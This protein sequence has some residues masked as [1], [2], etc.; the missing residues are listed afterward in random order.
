MKL[1]IALCLA[2]GCLIVGR[3]EARAATLPVAHDAT[4]REALRQSSGF[5]KSQ[6]FEKAIAAVLPLA[7]AHADDYTLNVRLGWLNYLD[8]KYDASE[9]SYRAAIEAAPQ[10]IE[11][12]LG[13]LLPLLA[14]AKYQTAESV[15][16]QILETDPA[17][18]L[19]NLRLAVALRLQLKLDEAQEIVESNLAKYPADVYFQAE[20]AS[21]SIAGKP[22][23]PVDVALAKAIA[24]SA[25]FE[26]ALDFDKA[27]DA[28]GAQIKSH[29]RNYTLA[30]R[31]AWLHYLK[32]EYGIAER[33]YQ[34]AARLAPKS[35]EA[36]LGGLLAL[37]AELKYRNAEP[38]AQQVIRSDPSNYYA[39][40]RLAVAMRNL[41]KLPE[42][43]KVVH[44][45]LALYPA[46]TALMTELGLIAQA[47]NKPDRAKQLFLEVVALDSTNATALQQLDGLQSVGGSK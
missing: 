33:D 28:L 20:R 23:P 41:K 9:K 11:A 46:D 30:L 45:M 40:L 21:L 43:E 7:A 5:E 17:N 6:D 18:Y 19:A 15:A 24:E 32:G 13:L 44:K 36:K 31:S 26:T 42:A 27:L 29:P 37:L 25:R 38:L 39:N 2:A 34:Q 12:K 14:D 8:K 10:S 1:S 3:Q 35:I 16:R 22:A 4:I 47:E